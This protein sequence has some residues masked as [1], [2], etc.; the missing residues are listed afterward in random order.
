[1]KRLSRLVNHGWTKKTRWLAW[2]TESHDSAAMRVMPVLD[3][4][5]LMLTNCPMRPARLWVID[6]ISSN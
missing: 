1:M 4:K 2:R 3:A 5:E 6:S